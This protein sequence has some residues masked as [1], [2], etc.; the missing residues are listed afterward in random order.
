MAGGFPNGNPDGYGWVD[1]GV[2]LPLGADRTAEYYF[3]RYFAV[4]PEQM[5]LQTYYNPFE[6]RG[7]RYIPYCGAGGDH[8]MGGPPTA[9]SHLPVSPYADD[10]GRRP[11]GPRP[12]FERTDRGSRSSAVGCLAVADPV[13]LTMKAE[14]IS[15]RLPAC[16]RPASALGGC[17][18]SCQ[19]RRGLLAWIDRGTARASRPEAVIA[20]TIRRRDP[21]ARNRSNLSGRSIVATPT[22]SRRGRSSA[23]RGS[24]L[25]H[26]RVS[27]DCR[28]RGRRLT[29]AERG[30]RCVSSFDSIIQHDAF[31]PDRDARPRV[32]TVRRRSRRFRSRFH[33]E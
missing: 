13:R 31:G 3:P 22:W 14:R 24:S 10:T 32:S 33:H 12:S 17:S 9:S 6:T 8:P 2:Y 18:G 30:E 7:Q 16:H 20:G 28:A 19:S 23:G 11:G 5:F 4:P 27:P 15:W 26:D 1:Y 21:T 25:C 29:G